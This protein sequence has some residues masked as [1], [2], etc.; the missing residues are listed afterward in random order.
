MECLWTPW[1][2]QYIEENNYHEKC[3]FCHAHN[4]TDD[5]ENLIVYRGERAFVMLNL[6]P[7]TTGHLMVLPY[8][9]QARLEDL[10]SE[11]R[12]EMM[13]LVN[14]SLKVIRSVYHPGGF[15]VGANLGKAAGAG[16]P[17]HIHWHIVPR[18]SGDTN[19]ISSI[20]E[21]RILPEDIET[22][23]HR[24]LMAWDNL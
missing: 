13:E 9:H 3:I 21:T 20:G 17:D 1:R 16:I 7:Y 12:A 5:S 2:M 10:K 23:Y 8:L 14:T 11:T 15:N 4:G 18:W 22:T 24:L 19:F 6:Y